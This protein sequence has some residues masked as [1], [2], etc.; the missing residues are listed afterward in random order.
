M[1]RF[2]LTSLASVVLT[3]LVVAQVQGPTGNVRTTAAVV[4]TLFTSTVTSSG[5]P[6]V[7]PQHNVRLTA[8]KYTI[9]PGVS[10]P[11]HKH[12][13]PRYAYVLSGSVRVTDATTGT[14]QVFG[15]GGFI[16]EMVNRWHTGQPAGPEAVE[17][18]VID[19]VEGD[20]KNVIARD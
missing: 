12:L 20:G 10:L 2:V 14:S 18:L 15:Q 17:L 19:L 13:F 4:K 16:I 3:L 9:P 1:F 6:M 7:L 5:D 11:V 8:S